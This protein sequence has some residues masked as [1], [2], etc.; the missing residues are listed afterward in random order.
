MATNKKPKV[1]SDPEILGGTPV[2]EGTRVPAGN[3]L[4][5]VQAG[6]SDLEIFLNYPSLPPYSVE[7]VI[8]WNKAG[9]PV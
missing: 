6:T 3:I 7:A 2:V 4:V 1:V 9:R 5:E 8:E